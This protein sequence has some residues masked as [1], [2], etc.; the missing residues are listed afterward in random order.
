MPDRLPHFPLAV[1]V[2][3]PAPAGFSEAAR[4]AMHDLLKK[5]GEDAPGGIHVIQ[6]AGSSG[7]VKEDA[8]F[9]VFS[10]PADLSQGGG[11]MDFVEMSDLFVLVA[12]A[13]KESP[14]G[15]LADYAR[16]IGR[17]VITID[18]E[19][20]KLDGE[21]P[22]RIEDHQDWLPE[23]FEQA[24]LTPGADLQLVKTQMS[25]LAK[26]SAPMARVGAHWI[27]VLQGL[28]LCV[29]LAWLTQKVL[30]LP[31]LGIVGATTLSAALLLM[32]AIWW[33]R[34]RGMQKTWARSR[35]VAEAARSL[36]A[37]GE[38]AGTPAWGSLGVIP[39]L[40]PLRWLPAPASPA[41]PFPQW[42]DHYIEARIDQQ[43][44]FF[45]KN[46][47][48]AQKR[49]KQFSTWTTIV[50]DLVLAIAFFG[51]AMAFF[52]QRWLDESGGEFVQ[53]LFGVGGVVFAGILVLI[54]VL[55]D[56]Q[57]LTWR[58]ARYAQQQ[59]FL[60]Q[61]R[62]RLARMPSEEAALEVVDNTE[63]ELLAEVME[64][65]FHAET[66]EHFV[67]MQD[68]HDKTRAAA[69]LR[70]TE[71]GF[72]GKLM[73]R[74]AVNTGTAGLFVLRVVF[75]RLPWVLGA[76]AIAIV[77]IGY[78]A[79]GHAPD[80]HQF[81][82][83]VHL[84]SPS[85]SDFAPKPEET[86]RGCVVLVHGLY[87]GAVS[88]SGDDAWI[89]TCAVQ[90]EKRMVDEGIGKP[91]ICLID[92]KGAARP[93]RFFHLGFGEKMLLAD[94][95]AIRPQAYRV[96][97]YAADQIAKFINEG[98]I[99]RNKPIHLIGHSAGGFIVA[100]VAA[101]LTGM[102]F[103][104]TNKDLLATILDTPLPDTALTTD[105]P[106]IWPTDYCITSARVMK[107]PFDAV[108]EVNG[109][110]LRIKSP[111]YLEILTEL[112]KRPNPVTGFWPS[113]GHWLWGGATDFVQAHSS[114][115]GWF[116]LTIDKNNSKYA[117]EGFNRSPL[118]KQK[119][120]APNP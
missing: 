97:D 46:R 116:E 53:A 12:H 109:L 84:W 62:L 83:T 67:R 85:Q 17:T 37:A 58:T 13:A 45:K 51:A 76:L 65:Y 90:I 96:G 101:R 112:R 75:G 11:S 92:W 42:R 117:T 35:L 47:E 98:K 66:A 115:Y 79:G 104:A 105:L 59:Q 55:R 120:A 78:N 39:A 89:K 19:T 2:F 95:A 88:D 99:D 18:P 26:K 43:V 1:G 21:I 50:L 72:A 102:G 28:A 15:D 63:N 54:Q 34:W 114:A 8:G 16:K 100:R 60:E 31:S 25:A 38:W 69:P 68:A 91:A 57:D 4:R 30:G 113:I 107:A 103:V 94:L 52:G 86:A 74:V 73:G 14:S 77:W 49:R 22:A 70:T 71:R 27:V 9:Q 110:D 80:F 108:K 106:K 87:S 64:W 111:D 93:S 81:E 61:A 118:L 20:G 33:L 40:R 10:A 3:E 41:L 5:L 23:L 29:P 82:T 36:L 48:E 44:K 119:A 32:A 6:T 7:L 24:E 56:L